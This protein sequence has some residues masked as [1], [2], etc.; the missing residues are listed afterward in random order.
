MSTFEWLSVMSAVALAM[1]TLA[2]GVGGFTVR[3]ALERLST[4]EGHRSDD[5][6]RLAVI[7]AGAARAAGYETRLSALE[8]GLADLRADIKVVRAIVEGLARHNEK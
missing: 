8:S 7:E 5:Q 2:G 4:L 1:V 6:S 3:Q